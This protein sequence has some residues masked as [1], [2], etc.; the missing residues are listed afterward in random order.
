MLLGLPLLYLGVHLVFQVDTYYPRHIVA[1]HL[2]MAVVALYAIGRG[3]G[4]APDA[5]DR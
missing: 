5:P 3:F 4:P 2:A 1:G